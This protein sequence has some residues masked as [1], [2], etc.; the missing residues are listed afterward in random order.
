MLPAIFWIG[1]AALAYVYVVYPAVMVVLAELFPSAVRRR[2]SLPSVSV[3]VVAHDEQERVDARLDNL[4]ALD[5]PENRVEILLGSDGSTDDTVA[6]ARRFEGRRV[7]VFPF[8]IR[9]GKAAVLNDLAARAEGEVLAFADAR[10]TFAPDALRALMAP[11]ADPRVGGVSGA[12]ILRGEE[13]SDVG[14][15]VSLYWRYEKAIREAESALDATVGATGSIYA[16]RRLLFTPIPP[17]TILDD[18]LIPMRVA[19]AGYRVLF[20]PLALAYDTPPKEA[21]GE[22]ARKVRTIA[23][24]FQLFAREPWMLDP[25]KNRLW[26]QTVSHKGLRLLGPAF[27]AATLVSSALLAERPFYLA[28]LAGQVGIL[29]AAGLDR[30]LRPRGVR[31]PLLSA[32]FVFVLLQA[33]TIAAFVRFVAGRATG[34]W[35]GVGYG[36]SPS[37]SSRSSLRS[38]R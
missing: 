38:S 36:A 17:D 23:G 3:L 15:G 19:R 34:T 18:V 5:Y 11:F 10:Q 14:D 25:R 12:L 2:L 28:A 37:N 20:E 4:L 8:P 27:L 24:N 31:V 7:R 32:A 30:W 21:R 35:E 1:F 13:G 6:L 9:R 26:L 16:V 29:L 22:F 33:A